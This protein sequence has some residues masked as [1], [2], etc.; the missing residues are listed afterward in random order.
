V[1]SR[2]AELSRQIHGLVGVIFQVSRAVLGMFIVSN[3]F[4]LDSGKHVSQYGHTAWR[5]QDGFLPGVPTAIAQTRDGYLW[6]G[7]YS[8]LVRFDGAKFVRFTVSAGESLRN[9]LITS[10]FADRDGS[11][12]I[13]TG[14]D[15]EHWQ[16]GR[17]THFPQQPGFSFGYVQMIFRSREG[18]LWIVRDPTAYDTLGP[19]CSLQ[20]MSLQCFNQ[21][22][23]VGL[24]RALDALEDKDGSFW[25]HDDTSLI[26]WDPKTHRALSGGI[27]GVAAYRSF[28]RSILDGEGTVLM[29]LEQSG[30][31][32][33]AR[34]R[35]GQIEPYKAG[36]FDGRQIAAATA[37]YRDSK[38]SLWIA[39]DKDGLYRVTGAQVDQ[40]G[41]SDGLSSNSTSGFFEDREG[42]I[43]AFTREGVD[44]FRDMVVTT[45]SARE[46]LSSNDVSAVLAASDGTVWI[47]NFTS[48]DALHPDGAVTSFRAGKGLPGQ[49]VAAMTEDRKK[50]LWV[51]IDNGLYIFDGKAF[52]KLRRSSGQPIGSIKSLVTDCDG[53]VWAISR[54]PPP[55][56]SLLHF[57][58]DELKEEIS[59]DEL[60][61]AKA[62]HM[63][64]DPQDGIW[65]PLEGDRVAHWSHGR[66]E[67]VGLHGTQDPFSL[68]TVTALVVR[69]QDFVFV[70]STAGV[71]VIRNGQVRT[72]SI[73]QGLP[74]AGI[75]SM[76]DNDDALWLNS[77]CGAIEL[78]YSELE[79]WWGNPSVRPQMLLLDP[80]DGMQPGASSHIPRAAHSLDGRVWFANDSVLQ[81]IDPRTISSAG[82]LPAVLIE[83]LAADGRTYPLSR[84]IVLP[85]LSKDVQIDYTAPSFAT[86]QRVHFRYKLDGLEDKWVD[87]GNRRQALFSNLRPGVY[88][89]RVS[90]TTGNLPWSGAE[91]VIAF[92]VPPRFYQTTWFIAL[93]VATVL[94]AMLLLYRIR[95][96]TIKRNLRARLQVRLDERERIARDLHDTLFQ[97]IQGVLLTIDNSTNKL[98]DG[99]SI[100]G[101][102]KDALRLSDKVMADSRERVLDLRADDMPGKSIG[103]ALTQLGQDLERQ[104][105][106]AFR[107]IELGTPENLHPV[108]FDEVFRICSEALLNAF[109]HSHA[110]RIE[111]EILFGHDSFSIRIGDN[112]IGIAEGVLSEGGKSG[113]FGLKVMAERARKLGAKFTIRSKRNAGTE[114]ELSM[115]RTVACGSRG[116]RWRWPWIGRRGSGTP[117]Q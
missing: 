61:F 25:I 62:T 15:L 86:P 56:G 4:G 18:L 112:G 75:W 11:L 72:L 44:R 77:E 13:G 103:Q 110:E 68:A 57:A 29:A 28:V 69:P 100:R 52:T 113:H 80:L 102:L 17:L 64:A 70:S 42:D 99:N 79:R 5:V 55:F 38:G 53:D 2:I 14:S 6:I 115:P 26:H 27:E 71:K 97:S 37:V 34:A 33:I 49:I 83:Q 21:N 65:L 66:A 59:H 92:R 12:W 51:G 45:Y 107:V 117:I 20:G 43:W 105:G 78:H 94:L 106:G 1:L 3:A 36:S 114:L 101:E 81:M 104:Y 50:R 24:T 9:P 90:A 96:D 111:A 109:R 91:S 87:S 41:R 7:T 48:L 84:E 8:G 54:S 47:N 93:C 82:P 32:G 108:V 16:D 67:I 74:C 35:N 63:S 73:E 98:P 58:G 40:Y 89:F 85:P 116:A 46:G 60:P 39:T 88:R 30:S 23:G 22:D 76:T 31:V 95:V 19:V 10:L